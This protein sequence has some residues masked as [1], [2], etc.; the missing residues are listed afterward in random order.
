MQPRPFTNSHWFIPVT[1]CAP[2]PFRSFRYSSPLG[3]FASKGENRARDLR[4]Q[5]SIR[6]RYV[7]NIAT[8]GSS[9]MDR[10]SDGFKPLVPNGSKET[11]LQIDTGEA[12]AI[13]NSREMSGTNRRIGN[14]TQNSTMNDSHGI[15]MKLGLSFHLHRSR[16]FTDLNQPDSES[17]HNGKRE[18]ERR[19]IQPNAAVAAGNE[20]NFF[21]KLTHIFLP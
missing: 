13:R 9:S 6:F 19:L 11:D 12:L 20:C 10:S 21:F 18:I 8:H 2:M 4:D 3:R 1:I 7:A 5:L 17:L 16:P 14:V 15:R